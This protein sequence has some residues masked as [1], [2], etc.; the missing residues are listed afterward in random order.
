MIASERV[1][2][3]FGCGIAGIIKASTGIKNAL[4]IVHGPV[5]CAAGHR[6]IPLLAGK[7]PLVP[8]TALTEI[9]VILGTEDRIRAS[10]EKA[11]D[12]YHPEMIVIILTCGTSLTGEIHTT[13]STS[14]QEKY[15]I[16]FFIL[17][18]SGTTGSDIEGYRSFYNS[19]RELEMKS[20]KPD[21]KISGIELIG[22]SEADFESN[23]L[24]SSL[25][26]LLT[27][28][29]GSPAER[30]LFQNINLKSDANKLFL[31][32]E[33]GY[34][35]MDG[36]S[37]Y[38]APVGVDG[39]SMWIQNASKI[40]KKPI[41]SLFQEQIDI[42]AQNVANFRKKYDLSSLKIGIEAGSWQAVGLGKFLSNELGCSVLIS[43]DKA[44]WDYQ[45]ANGFFAE[46]YIDM[47]N[48]E[49]VDKMESFGAQLVFGSSYSKFGNWS[50]VP[51]WQP[52]WHV[53]AEQGSFLGLKG[54]DRILKLL[55]SFMEHENAR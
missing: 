2:P 52:V 38:P 5:G 45:H 33:I 12:S 4:P 23:N 37:A 40:S 28:A 29:L 36:H 19:F 51:F 17:D 39:I 50:W 54:T 7:I 18:G 44:A 32:L 9:D 27:L 3:L 11:I 1:E 15:K 20:K 34:L 10:V 14:L 6:I 49:L 46:T 30:V 35:W 31:P 24:I 42:L 21:A 43:S 22:V 53:V 26:G 16:P 8:S 13:L 25:Q 55:E 47:A 41:N 48:I